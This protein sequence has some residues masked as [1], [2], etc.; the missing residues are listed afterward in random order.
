MQ[1]TK[2]HQTFHSIFIKALCTK[3]IKIG[4]KYAEV[5]ISVQ[6]SLIESYGGGLEAKN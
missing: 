5:H 2:L 6:K 3:S 1:T 4:L